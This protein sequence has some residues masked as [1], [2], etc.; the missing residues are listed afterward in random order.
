VAASADAGL[1]GATGINGRASGKEP[2][3]VFLA[4]LLLVR[5]PTDLTN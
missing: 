3:L 2:T 5:V 4:R 1:E